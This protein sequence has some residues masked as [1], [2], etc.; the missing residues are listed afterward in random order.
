LVWSCLQQNFSQQS[1]A[2]A[3]N[4][5]FQ[6]LSGNQSISQ[7]LQHAKNLADSLAAINEP[8]SNV[9]L[10]TSVLRGLGPDYAMLVTAIIPPLP[11]FPDLR[12]RL[13]S[14]ESQ[15]TT[16]IP[17]SN[18]SHPTAFVTTRG[19]GRYG[20]GRG[21]GRGDSFRGRGGRAIRFG[22]GGRGCFFSNSGLLGPTPSSDFDGR[23]VQCQAQFVESLSILLSLVVFVTAVDDDLSKSFA[24]MQ[25]THSYDY[26]PNWYPDTGSTNHMTGD[27]RSM[28]Q[29]SEYV[30]NDQVMVGNGDS[31]PIA[32]WYGFSF[33][34]SGSISSFESVTCSYHA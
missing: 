8:V 10:V 31:L 27:A 13:L 9:D 3:T 24:G 20:H 29:K 28:T 6:L 15:L 2:N 1:L 34:P 4:L 19:R 14:F 30:G 21:R 16:Q 12:A 32:N 33:G 26:D 25:I 22:R 7:Y 23:R 5:R 17:S 11:S 18:S